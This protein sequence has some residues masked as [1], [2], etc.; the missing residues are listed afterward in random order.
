MRIEVMPASELPAPLPDKSAPLARRADGTIANSET[1]RALGARGGFKKA[2]KAKLLT[3]LGLAEL[4]EEDAFRPYWIAVDDW[5]RAHLA[6]LAGM[7]GGMVGPG[8]ASIV[9][10]AGVQLAASRFFSDMGAKQGNARIFETASKLGN[11]SRQNLLAAYELARREG[12]VRKDNID[13]HEALLGALNVDV[14]S[15]STPN[16]P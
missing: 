1:A 7:C 15:G 6:V 16:K 3:G 8:P 2:T 4:T 5:V 13:P 10:T 9:G 14:I 11:D 12:E